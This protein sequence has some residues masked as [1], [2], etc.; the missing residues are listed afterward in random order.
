[1]GINGLLPRILPSAGREN[2]DLRA[3][4]HGLVVV[5]PS[6]DNRTANI[7]E[8]DKKRRRWTRRKVRIAVDVNGWIARAAHGYGGSLM[9]ERHLSYHGR[10]E[11]RNEQLQQQ[12]QS[13]EGGEGQ[14]SDQISDSNLIQKQQ[15]LE[16]ISKCISFVLQRIEYMR[17]ECCAMVLPVLDGAT[18]PCKRDAVRERSNRRKLATEQRDELAAHQSPPRPRDA[19]NTNSEGEAECEE[20]EAART[21]A[22]VLRRI[23]ASKRAGTG[24]DYSMRQEIL[25]ELLKEF[26]RRRWPFLVAPYEADGQLAYLANT[27]GVDLVVTEDSDLI[28]LGVPTLVYRMGG[29][30]GS[31]S[32]NRAPGGGS[33][34]GSIHGPSS[35]ASGNLRGTMLNRR[36]L[37]SSHGINLLDF[38]DAM[39]ATMFVA[40]GCDYCDSLKGIGIV[41]A[42]NIV[43]RAFHGAEANDSGGYFRQTEEPVLRLILNE[44]FRSCHKNAREQVLPLDD[45]EKEEV[46]LAYERSFLA[47]L[48]MFRHPLVYD[49]MSGAHAVANDVCD[50]SEGIA[51][52]SSSFFR[53]ERVLME[54]GPYRELVT[55][56]EMLYQV[57]GMPFVPEIAKGIAEGIIDPRQLPVQEPGERNASRLAHEEDEHEVLQKNSHA[58]DEDGEAGAG[59]LTQGSS[60]LQLSSQDFS[61]VGT[62]QSKSSSAASGL[63]SSLSPDLLASPS[64]QKQS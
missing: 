17:N 10:A 27:G 31:N 63:I 5:T 54:Y 56:R 11:L 30:N 64:P 39:L 46:R 24:K 7:D 29:W 28:A 45:P 3:L 36:D 12:R 44:L 19:N 22:E 4:S 59:D 43:K 61:G 47:A 57:I 55:R 16:Y 18:P 23:S 41:T 49:P 32:A 20:N 58:Q 40:A 13:L 48:A 15:R 42:R 38:S 35:S 50:E 34:F 37:G 14:A 52:A 60:G 62:Q 25:G 8:P 33:N 1:M 21:E 26:R 9:D 6:G 2:Y 53:D 51:P